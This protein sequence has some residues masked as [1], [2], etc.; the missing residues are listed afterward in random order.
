M[1]P[2][3]T[4]ISTSAADKSI[5]FDYQFYYFFLLILDL[6]IGQKIG[7]EVKDDVHIDLPDGSLVLI[8]T[9]HTT[10]KNSQNQPINL[11]ELDNDLWH[12]LSNWALIISEQENKIDF[13]NKTTFEIVSNKLT[14]KNKFELMTI[15][16]QSGRED[17]TYIKNYLGNILIKTKNEVLVEYIS[18]VNRLPNDQ[19]ELF[20][21][22]IKLQINKDDLIKKIKERL[23]ENIHIEK[24]IDQIYKSLHSELRDLIYLSTKAGDKIELSFDE[25]NT[26]FGRCYEIA[27][28]DKLPIRKPTFTLPDDLNSQ[29]FIRQLIDIEDISEDDSDKIVEYTTHKLLMHN[30]LETW[31][32]EG[33]IS[34]EEVEQFKYDAKKIH[35]RIFH[36]KYRIIKRKRLSE[37]ELI[38]IESDIKEISL[39]ILDEVR[40]EQL[41]LSTNPLS[42]QMSNGQFYSLNDTHEIGWHYSW[43]N[44]Y[45]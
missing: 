30:S 8:Q 15:E 35:E 23:L 17:I 6:K 31:N 4:Q 5:G 2:T 1:E 29:L 12:T 24:K 41:I 44:R 18:N 45:I 25:F 37:T 19:L 36:M 7:Y 34:N 13:L 40:S 43:N 3:P 9:K 22:K 26:K 16:A 28:S 38:E 27:L 14:S 11:T 33:Y 42:H 39:Q 21:K 10:Q 20:I 32:K